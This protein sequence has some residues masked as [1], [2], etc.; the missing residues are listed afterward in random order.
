MEQEHFIV[1][2]TYTEEYLLPTRVRDTPEEA[3]KEFF[4]DFDLNRHHA[5]RDGNRIG[6]SK[7]LVKAEI[8]KTGIK[9]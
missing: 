9:F 1:R 8:T 6:N 5:T 4:T 2:V 7:K 3:V